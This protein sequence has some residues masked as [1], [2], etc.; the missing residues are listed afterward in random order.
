M[1][2]KQITVFDTHSI[3]EG[4]VLFIKIED[5]YKKALVETSNEKYLKLAYIND[6]GT[7]SSVVV[8]INEYIEDN[9]LIK[10]AHC[11]MR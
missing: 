3:H 8:L 9:L 7:I 2:T 11:Y 1:I 6:A 10:P 5:E 4:D